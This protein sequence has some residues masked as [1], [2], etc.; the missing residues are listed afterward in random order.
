MGLPNDFSAPFSGHK[1]DRILFYS[2][3]VVLIEE[4]KQ[5]WIPGPCPGWQGRILCFCG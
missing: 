2:R 4:I 5:I 3:G 1:L